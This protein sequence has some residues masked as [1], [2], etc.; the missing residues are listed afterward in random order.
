[1][2]YLSVLRATEKKT[3]AAGGVFD[4]KE[5]LDKINNDKMPPSRRK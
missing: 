1:M 5:F 2:Y 4:S 3:E